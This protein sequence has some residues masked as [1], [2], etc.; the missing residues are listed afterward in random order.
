MHYSRIVK[1]STIEVPVTKEVFK[2]IIKYVSGILKSILI[3]ISSK[4]IERFPQNE[5]LEAMYVVYPQF[6]VPSHCQLDLFHT[7]VI[8]LAEHFSKSS[9]YNGQKIE[10]I[11]N[12][13]KLREQATHFAITMIEQFD[14]MENPMLV[15]SITRVWVTFGQSGI[16]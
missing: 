13:T 8:T 16:L 4:F 10:G 15:G 11:I 6:W 3:S 12:V 9:E 7:K 1:C 14:S 2:E 5:I